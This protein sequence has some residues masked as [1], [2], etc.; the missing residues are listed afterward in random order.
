MKAR[1]WRTSLFNSFGSNVAFALQKCQGEGDQ[2]DLFRVG[3]YVNEKLTRIP[4]CSEL[5]C[6]FQEFFR[7]FESSRECSLEEL[8]ALDSREEE[9][10]VLE[11]ATDDRF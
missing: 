7:V 11:A 10:G 8:C 4:G 9:E 5:W 1:K 2:E 3:M 6:E